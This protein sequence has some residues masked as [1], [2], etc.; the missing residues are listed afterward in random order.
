MINAF[1]NDS[2]P[3]KKI[4]EKE[5]LKEELKKTELKAYKLEAASKYI[6]F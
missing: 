5:E 1:M 3:D 4:W 2:F 6:S